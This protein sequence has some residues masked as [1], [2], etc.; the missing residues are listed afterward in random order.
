MAVGVKTRYAVAVMIA[1]FSWF[2]RLVEW[3][4]S[5]IQMAVM[6]ETPIT[7]RLSLSLGAGRFLD[8][9]HPTA[10]TAI[11]GRIDLFTIWCTFL[12]GLGFMVAGKASR[13]QAILIAVL[14]WIAGAIFPLWG[15]LKS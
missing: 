8:G 7:S 13:N 2:P 1:T 3:I 12:L 4:A 11:V 14:V 10:V 6:P 5:A 9:G 15:A